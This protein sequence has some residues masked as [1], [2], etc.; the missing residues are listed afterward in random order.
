VQI[1]SERRPRFF[2]RT[3][4]RLAGRM[5]SVEL[6]GAARNHP[7]ARGLVALGL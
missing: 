6:L 7:R 2:L 1:G 4:S 5:G 3:I